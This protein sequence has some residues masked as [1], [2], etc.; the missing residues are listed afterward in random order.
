MFFFLII[1]KVERFILVLRGTAGD[2]LLIG[3]DRGV[4]LGVD[5]ADKRPTGL[6]NLWLRIFSF[7]SGTIIQAG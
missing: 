7:P 3:V 2:K 5:P 4:D 1:Y 6:V